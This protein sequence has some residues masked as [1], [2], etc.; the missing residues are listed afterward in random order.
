MRTHI[1]VCYGSAQQNFVLADVDI[2][3]L[4]DSHVDSFIRL[5]PGGIALKYLLTLLLDRARFIIVF[6]LFDKPIIVVCKF[7]L[8]FCD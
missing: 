2:L 6:R 4:I 8:F 5:M 7:S 3:H 1:N